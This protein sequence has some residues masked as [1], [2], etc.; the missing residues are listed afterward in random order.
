[1]YKH[2]EEEMKKLAAI[3][4]IMVLGTLLLPG[5]SLAQETV[6]CEVEYTVQKRV[7]Q[8]ITSRWL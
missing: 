7:T 1:M 6:E 2:S 5:T 8:L 4:V 3:L